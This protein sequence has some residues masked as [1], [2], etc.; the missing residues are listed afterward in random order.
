MTEPRD[1][2][3]P[4]AEDPVASTSSEAALAPAVPPPLTA[5]TTPVVASTAPAPGRKR[6][7]RR[8]FRIRGVRGPVEVLIRA[9]LV[10]NVA[11]I[12]VILIF[13]LTSGRDAPGHPDQAS[14]SGSFDLMSM[15]LAHIPTSASCLLCH[16]SG[17]SGGLKPVPAIG[18][19]LEG[20][21]RCLTCH[22][23]ESLGRR[24]P[25]HVGIPEEECLNCH[26]LPPEGPTI[27]Q[28]HS[29]LQDQ[30]CLDC[31]GTFAHL[32]TSMVGRNQDECW[33]CHKPAALPPPEY[34]HEPGTAVGCRECHQSAQTGGLPIDH[35]RRENSTCLL[36]HDIKAT[37]PLPL[38]TPAPDASLPPPSS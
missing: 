32:P 7:A 22:T 15:G 27:T 18:H 37:G 38:L 34:P 21:R 17:G 14:P 19:P 25:G 1:P 20:W 6:P 31:H 33:L 24:A 13:V 11:V 35:A 16:E 28:P 3:L 5:E 8:R 12:A 4:P 26:K 9:L 23:N 29:R 2:G 30:H 10:A 36:C